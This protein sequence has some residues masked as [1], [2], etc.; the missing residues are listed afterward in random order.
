[1]GTDGDHMHVGTDGDHMHVG[2]D[3][4]TIA[5]GYHCMWVLMGTIACG[6]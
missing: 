5:C 6:Y 4:G 1:M 2:T 3:M